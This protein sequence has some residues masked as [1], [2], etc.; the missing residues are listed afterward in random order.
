MYQPS[1]CGDVI[2]KQLFFG[3]VLLHHRVHTL[4]ALSQVVH[5]VTADVQEPTV[6]VQRYDIVNHALNK[7]ASAV[8]SRTNNL[9][10]KENHMNCMLLILLT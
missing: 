9:F 6:R 3:P 8:T 5:L 7:L 10:T 4:V 2:K 1:H